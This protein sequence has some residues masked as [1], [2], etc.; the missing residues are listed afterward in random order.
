[1]ILV[2][3]DTLTTVEKV[4]EI[5]GHVRFHEIKKIEKIVDAVREYVDIKRLMEISKG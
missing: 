4:G 2:N 1:M 5:I 3:F